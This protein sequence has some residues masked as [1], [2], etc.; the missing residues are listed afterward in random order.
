MSGGFMIERFT[1]PGGAANLKDAMLQQR[2]VQHD[3][4][5][6]DKLIAAGTPGEHQPG[7]A[8]LQQGAAD[9]AVF[10]ILTGEANVE[11]NGRTVAVRTA[12]ET[13]GEMVAVD[14]TAPRSATIV[15][16]VESV[17]LS[18][19]SADF[20][21]IANEHP[22]VWRATARVVGDRLRQRHRFHRAPNPKP[23]LF[24]GS[25]VEGLQVAKHIQLGLQRS[26]VEVRIWTNGVFGP[27]GVTVDDL[28][29]QV[30]EADFS[31]FVFGPDDKVA[32]RDEQ[33]QAPRDN[34]VFEMG[35]FISK[36]GRDRTYIVKDSKSDL[37]IPSDLLG[38][39]PIVYV[40]D[41]KGKP[42][43]VFGPVC[44]TLEKQVRE[45]GSI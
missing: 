29:T 14:Q 18:V 25:S 28:I 9:D 15:A 38:I 41:P 34:V 7:D 22:K 26:N 19:P 13:V 44:T 6:A 27:G 40:A 16:N 3:E 23:I 2:I 10:F 37:K 4:V 5:V 31:A 32:S 33:Y 39:T 30:E 43:V 42:E 11:V 35:M 20:I 17:T 24:I 8:I 12:T 1:G 21:R 45:L 36:L